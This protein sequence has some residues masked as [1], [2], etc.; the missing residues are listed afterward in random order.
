MDISIWEAAKRGDVNQMA[1]RLAEGVHV[2]DEDEGD[3][4]ASETPLRI[5]AA[6]GHIHAVEFLIEAKANLN[7][8]HDD[9]YTALMAAALDGQGDIAGLLVRSR[10]DCAIKNRQGKTAEQIAMQEGYMHM[11]FLLSERNHH[12]W[13]VCCHDSAEPF[14]LV[15]C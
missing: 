7:F 12:K 6:Q 3:D 11:S 13:L 14:L 10:A 2:D 5:A 15:L 1:A 4:D 9:G 8:C